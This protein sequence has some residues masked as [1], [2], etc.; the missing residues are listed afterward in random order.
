MRYLG[1]CAPLC[2]TFGHDTFYISFTLEGT[3]IMLV[4]IYIIS[5]GTTTTQS[6]RCNLFPN[7]TVDT[8][9]QKANQA[10]K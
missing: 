8:T 1:P 2:T 7:T 6:R 9:R 10:H 5:N 4:T 3:F